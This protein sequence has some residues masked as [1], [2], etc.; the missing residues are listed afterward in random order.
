MAS[1]ATGQLS[2]QLVDGQ[3]LVNQVSQASDLTPAKLMRAMTDKPGAFNKFTHDKECA[4]A[5]LKVGMS[6]LLQQD[7]L[8]YVGLGAQLVP[9]EL[10]NVLRGCLIADLKHRLEQARH[11]ALSFTNNEE[12]DVMVLD[13]KMPGIDGIEVLRRFK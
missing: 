6:Q 13:L 8:V 3:A 12:P 11:L 9:A 1:E 5:F 10:S 4:V 2:Y 7:K